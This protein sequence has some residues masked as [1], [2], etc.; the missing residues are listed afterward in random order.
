[1]S[2]DAT[3][4]P[5]TDGS[6]VP[7]TPEELVGS[8][9]DDGPDGDDDPTGRA[10]VLSALEVAFAGLTGSGDV[11]ILPAEG[12]DGMDIALAGD[13]WTL[14]LSGWPGPATA[15]V[16][17][18]DE[19]DEDADS[20]AVEAAWR[21]AVPSTVIDAMAVADMEMDGALTAALIASAD[22]LSASIAKAILGE[23]TGHPQVT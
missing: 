14:Y 15:F 4:R 6:D 23:T 18:E 7:L 20:N 9:P 12:D 19:P 5:V 22:P 11:D 3:D 21:S 2:D 1:M 10:A 8:V 17:V 13:V 16:A